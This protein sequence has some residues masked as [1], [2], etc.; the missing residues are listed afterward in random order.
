VTTLLREMV[1]RSSRPGPRD[2]RDGRTSS[3]ESSL[4]GWKAC[5]DA[6]LPQLDDAALVE[7]LKQPGGAGETRAAL[8]E[9]LGKR[10]KRSFGDVW[11][12]VEYLAEAAPE[13]DLDAPL[14]PVK[15]TPRVRSRDEGE[16]G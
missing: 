8:L 2:F 9:H 6:L 11:E 10:C 12:L 7:L 1:R 4:P 16:E 3:L 13:L 5:L 15:A 14:R